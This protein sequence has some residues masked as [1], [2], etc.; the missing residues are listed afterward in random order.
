M[1][2]RN[3]DGVRRRT[4][5]K[6]AKEKPETVGLVACSDEAE[7]GLPKDAEESAQVRPAPADEAKSKG[8]GLNGTVVRKR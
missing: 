7:A 6:G 2:R 1:L 4:P 3:G 8:S 5:E